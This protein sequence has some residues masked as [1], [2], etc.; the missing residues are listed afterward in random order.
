M[1]PTTP[2]TAREMW[3][4]L[5]AR[6]PAALDRSRKMTALFQKTF[7][8]GHGHSLR[9]HLASNPRIS[10]LHPTAAPLLLEHGRDYIPQLL[11]YSH[12]KRKLQ[13][14]PNVCYKNARDVMEGGAPG[15]E[16]GNGAGVYVEGILHWPFD[17]PMLHAWNA[18]SL[19]GTVAIDWTLYAISGWCRYFG[20]SFSSEEY[21][22]VTADSTDGCDPSLLGRHSFPRRKR[23]I[24][25]VLAARKNPAA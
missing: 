11:G 18:R 7:P 13:P 10:Q 25:E 15:A 20:M 5:R 3:E 1:T 19:D 8:E 23:L 6:T 9:S 17:K 21:K 4:T 22:Y 2:T 12:Y 24:Q 14:L 16:P